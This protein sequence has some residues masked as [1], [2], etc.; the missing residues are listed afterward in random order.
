MWKTRLLCVYDV[1]YEVIWFWCSYVPPCLPKNLGSNDPA[2]LL[3]RTDRYPAQRLE[4]FVA[5]CFL[6]YGE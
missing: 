1:S 2:G 3:N 4:Q 6:L 5:Q